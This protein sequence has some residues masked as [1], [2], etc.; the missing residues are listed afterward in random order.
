MSITTRL[1]SVILLLGV[2][3]SCKKEADIAPPVIC[4]V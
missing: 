3:I 1:L 4:R 2:G